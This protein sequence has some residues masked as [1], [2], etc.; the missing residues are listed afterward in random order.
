MLQIPWC[1]FDHC[2]SFQG[3]RNNL[4]QSGQLETRE[5]YSLTVQATRCQKSR[6]QPCWVLWGSKGE[7]APGLSSSFQWLLT[8]LD[9]PWLWQRHSKFCLSSGGIAPTFS[10]PFYQ[11]FLL[12][13]SNVILQWQFMKVMGEQ[14]HLRAFCLAAHSTSIPAL[15][16]DMLRWL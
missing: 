6:C 1:L 15:Y 11:F 4:P 5:I 9:I 14:R 13:F 10:S 7:T 12:T 3:C 2:I 16:K 8:I